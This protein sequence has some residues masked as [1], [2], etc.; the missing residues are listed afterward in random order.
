MVA[1][2]DDLAATLR[3]QRIAKTGQPIP[4]Q[5]QG[6]SREKVREVLVRISLTNPDLIDAVYAL[7]DDEIGSWM[8]NAPKGASF[9][10]GATT[11]QIA[12][13]IGILQRG[14]TKLDREGRD[15]WIKPLRDLGGFEAIYLHE[16]Q[17][18]A[19]HPKPK[20]PSSAYKLED[21]FKAI[22]AAPAGTWQD[23]LAD[24]A[25]KD[26]ARQRLEFQAQIAEAA[27]GL[28]DNNHGELIRA[29]VDHYAAKFLPGFKVL[30]VD[31][32]DGDRISDEERQAMKE[33]GVELTLGDAMPDVLLWNPETDVLWV[34]EA[35]TSDGEVD[36]TKVNKMTEFA[37]RYNKAGVG[38]TTTYLTWKDAA[39][40]QSA[41]RNIAV[42]SFIWIQADP[43]KVLLVQSFD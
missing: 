1:K 16:G 38:F 3:E 11:A 6:V 14:K 15:Y 35:V 2:V 19:G 37:Q 43:A 18:I 34:I 32:S 24:W 13:H 8:A 7:L 9:A 33:A 5:L 22:L 36:I 23:M 31:D 4:D 12:C 41:H 17:F 40:R 42:G 25:S 21:A 29:S 27:K 20:S 26:A 28:V 30:Y 39:V 10:D